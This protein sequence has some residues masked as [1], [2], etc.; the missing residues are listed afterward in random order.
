MAGQSFIKIDDATQAMTEVK[1]TQTGGSGAENL[2]PALDNTGRLASS[3]MPSGVVPEVKIG[4]AFLAI[5]C[6]FK[7]LTQPQQIEAV[8]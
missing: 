2:I 7:M 6:L 3:M 4:N 1:A 5:R 8:Q